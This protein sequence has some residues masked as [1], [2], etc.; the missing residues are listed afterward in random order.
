MVFAEIP[1]KARIE[2]KDNV[3]TVRG[4]KLLLDK[5]AQMKAQFGNDPHKW[6]QQRVG[7]GEDILI[8][9][10]I[11]KANFEF[12]FCYTHEELCHC[13]N[14]ETDKVFGAIKNGC[15]KTEDVSRTTLAGTGCGSC[16]QDIANL[17]EQFKKP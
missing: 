13:R 4:S 17:I 12:K 7:S 1:Y 14:V 11:M 5:V 16:R 10:F 2:L 3:I 15:F 6:P 8:N 9:E